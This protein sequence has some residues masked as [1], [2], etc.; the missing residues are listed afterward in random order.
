MFLEIEGD[1]VHLRAIAAIDIAE[2]NIRTKE[3]RIETAVPGTAVTAPQ[4]GPSVGVSAVSADTELSSELSN[5]PDLGPSV[6]LITLHMTPNSTSLAI[7]PI[8]GLVKD[9]FSFLILILHLGECM[10]FY[11]YLEPQHSSYVD[12]FNV[13]RHAV[14]I[15]TLNSPFTSNF[16]H[17]C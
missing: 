8:S 16:G 6:K 11:V 17:L 7:I 13:T 5:F 2:N 4:G 15:W 10:D 3:P 1:D 12:I 9:F 14:L